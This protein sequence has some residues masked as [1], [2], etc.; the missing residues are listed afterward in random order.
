MA[1]TTH[2]TDADSCGT[3]ISRAEFGMAVTGCLSDRA[4][5]DVAQAFAEA[6]WRLAMQAGVIEIAAAGRT[7]SLGAA[8]TLFAEDHAL[9]ARVYHRCMSIWR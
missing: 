7:L 6:G 8:Y 3:L 9:H 5:G 4:Y 2:F 1:C